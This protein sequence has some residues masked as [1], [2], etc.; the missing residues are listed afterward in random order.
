MTNFRPDR[1]SN[2]VPRGIQAPVDTNE[3]SGSANGV[4][5]STRWINC[6]S[7]QKKLGEEILTNWEIMFALDEADFTFWV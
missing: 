1:D 2:L 4:M 6:D 7:I 5:R 3:P